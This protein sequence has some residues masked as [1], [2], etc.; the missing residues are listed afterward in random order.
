MHRRVHTI[1]V[2]GTIHMLV[3]MDDVSCLTR[4][5]DAYVLDHWSLSTWSMICICSPLLTS[6]PK[7]LPASILLFCSINHNVILLYTT[8]PSPD[9]LF[10][11]WIL[12]RSNNG[13]DNFHYSRHNGTG[14]EPCDQSYGQRY[15]D[16]FHCDYLE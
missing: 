14:A 1:V 8:G 3:A 12:T 15:I 7:Q 13:I 10:N 16:V 2:I 11:I 9:L 4:M 5:E 6:S